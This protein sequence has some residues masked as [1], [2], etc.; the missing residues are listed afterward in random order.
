MYRSEHVSDAGVLEALEKARAFWLERASI[1]LRLDDK[2]VRVLKD[3]DRSLEAPTSGRN[4]LEAMHT[5]NA[6]W[7]TVL[8]V[9][10]LFDRGSTFFRAPSLGYAAYGVVIRDRVSFVLA[11]EIGH[12]LGLSHPPEGNNADTDERVLGMPYTSFCLRPFEDDILA[13]P[14]VLETSNLMNTRLTGASEDLSTRWLSWSQ[15]DRARLTVVS[16]QCPLARFDPSG[17]WVSAPSEALLDDITGAFAAETLPIELRL[18][19]V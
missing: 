17:I 7:L 6:G 12:A 8:L 19:K 10:Q 1:E 13:L 2:G 11:H 16:R 15:V 14:R 3:D 5:P 9:G 4:G 18:G